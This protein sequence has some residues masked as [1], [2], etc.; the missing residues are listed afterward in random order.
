MS[1]EGTISVTVSFRD[2]TTSSGVQ[3]LKTITLQDATE[4]TTGKVA[5]VTGTV[6][7][8]SVSID[9]G[10]LSYRDSSGALVTFSAVTRAI[11]KSSAAALLSQSGTTLTF[12]SGGV[13]ISDLSSL[14][15]TLTLSTPG[16]TASY[17]LVLYGI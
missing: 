16:P 12:S 7:A 3:S 14:T 6:G 1:I 11:L 8:S 5:V 9:T 15:G 2:S 13:S 10:N 4:Y 17:T